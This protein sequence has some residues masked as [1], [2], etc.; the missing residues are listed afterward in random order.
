MHRLL[1]TRSGRV[2]I[3]AVVTAA[4]LWIIA[5]S[6]GRTAPHTVTGPAAAGTTGA[7][8]REPLATTDPVDPPAPVEPTATT[9]TAAPATAGPDQVA[10][11]FVTAWMSRG[12][13]E[14]PAGWLARMRPYAAQ[15]LLDQLALT[16]P[17]AVT[18]KKITGP[19]TVT[20][21]GEFGAQVTIG[22]DTGT[23]VCSLDT[24]GDRWTVIGIEPAR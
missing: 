16:A 2:L 18:A 19:V 12:P 7:P 3:A 22:T 23:V 21:S 20:T 1:H 24:T 10:V 11:G 14:P 9:P 5:M 13:S 17:G 4:V 15:V 6:S 8:A